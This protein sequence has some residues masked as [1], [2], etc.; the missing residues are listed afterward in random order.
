V[1]VLAGAQE[2]SGESWR[3]HQ[4]E[5]EAM[6]GEFKRVTGGALELASVERRSER[7]ERKEER[8]VDM[9]DPHAGVS[10][11]HRENQ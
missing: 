7:G 10:E 8:E 4:R 5:L 1:A 2:D 9:W 3:R 6:A 11:N